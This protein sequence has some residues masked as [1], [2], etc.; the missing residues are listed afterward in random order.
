MVDRFILHCVASVRPF[1]EQKRHSEH[2][3]ENSKN[4][5]IAIKQRKD[6]TGSSFKDL[7][8]TDWK[9]FS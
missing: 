8:K 6:C 9:F 1:S 7:L 5:R 2:E 3:V 4:R